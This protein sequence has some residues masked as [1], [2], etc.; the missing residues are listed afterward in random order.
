MA[1]IL[2]QLQA[3]FGCLGGPL[4]L[5]P[6]MAEEEEVRRQ[7]MRAA[8]AAREKEEAARI[9]AVLPAPEACEAAPPPPA[10]SPAKDAAAPAPAAALEEAK[11]ATGHAQEH[12]QDQ[13]GPT[14]AAEEQQS[15]VA[16]EWGWEDGDEGDESDGDDAL[17]QAPPFTAGAE[18]AV[19]PLTRLPTLDEIKARAAQG[20]TVRIKTAGNPFLDPL[21]IGAVVGQGDTFPQT[22][23]AQMDPDGDEEEE[24]E[25]DFFAD[26]AP[27]LVPAKKL[28]VDVEQEQALARSRLALQ[29]TDEEDAEGDDTWADDFDN[30][31]TAGGHGGKEKK[32][33]QV[34]KLSGVAFTFEDSDEELA[35]LDDLDFDDL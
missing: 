3:I 8:R 6:E 12:E 21:G 27:T 28:V 14:H 30:D 15:A 32:K 1:A 18:A 9:A 5:P 22:M 2:S 31:S 11:D 35:D 20:G 10:A 24:E 16:D 4:V 25:E 33:P 23:A 19:E 13:Q 7:R 17:G 29:Y 34:S 26:M